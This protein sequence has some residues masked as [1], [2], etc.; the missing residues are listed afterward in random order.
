MAEINAC[1][2]MP[3]LYFPF[4]K[5]NHELAAVDLSPKSSNLNTILH[6]P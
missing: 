1:L 3:M 6:T 2:Q 5:S 4:E